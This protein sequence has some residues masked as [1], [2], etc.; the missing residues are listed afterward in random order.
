MTGPHESVWQ[1]NEKYPK[2]FHNIIRNYSSNILRWYVKDNFQTLPVNQTINFKSCC[3]W[4]LKTM[5]GMRPYR[6][7][8]F[9]W[10]KNTMLRPQPIRPASRQLISQWTIE[11]CC[12]GIRSVSMRFCFYGVKFYCS[13]HIMLSNNDDDDDVCFCVFLCTTFHW[14]CSRLILTHLHTCSL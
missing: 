8:I 4:G 5:K 12:L 9:C 2:D 11:W 3:N 13:V 14:P 6:R 10:W 1:I 7:L